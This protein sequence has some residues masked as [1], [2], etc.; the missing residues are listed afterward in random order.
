MVVSERLNIQTSDIA[1]VIIR[2]IRP[3]D[4]SALM[5]FYNG[6]SESSKRTFR[7]IGYTTT[8]NVCKDIVKDNSPEIE[9]RFDLLAWHK[10]EIVGWGFLWNLESGEPTFGLGVADDFQGK[11][12]G[13]KLIDSL[14]ETA[15]E[16]EFK[17]VFLTVVQENEVAWKLYEKRGFV[18]YGEFVGE[19]GLDYFRMVAELD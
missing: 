12:L 6:L 4:E 13:S 2:R 10:T 5:D 18:K 14:M 16:G 1:S 3:G 15:R 8:L 17:K 7:P 9:K 19:D 11:S